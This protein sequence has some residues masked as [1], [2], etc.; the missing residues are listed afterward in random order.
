MG[1]SVI[2]D[3]K[4]KKLLTSRIILRHTNVTLLATRLSVVI[5]RKTGAVRSPYIYSML[6]RVVKERDTSQRIMN[7][8]QFLIGV[9][10]VQSLYRL[11]TG[12]TVRGSNPGGGEIFCTHPDRP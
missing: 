11:A 5:K 2:C 8:L 6:Y 4:K 10:I 3:M 12:W 9:G 7:M 1:T